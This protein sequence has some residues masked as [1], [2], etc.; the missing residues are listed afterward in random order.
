MWQFTI[1]AVEMNGENVSLLLAAK[2]LAADPLD[3]IGTLHYDSLSL[4]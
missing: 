2:A 1:A 3:N 4:R